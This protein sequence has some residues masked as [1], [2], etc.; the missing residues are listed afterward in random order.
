MM[1]MQCFCECLCFLFSA[2]LYKTICFGYSFELHQQADAIQMGTHNICL[3][4]EV[5]KSTVL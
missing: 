4:K 3:C 5:D 2:F 1:L